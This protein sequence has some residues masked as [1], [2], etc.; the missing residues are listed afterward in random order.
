MTP[1]TPS[2]SE[3]GQ[4]ES[5]LNSEHTDDDLELR[6]VLDGVRVEGNTRTNERVIRRYIPFQP[7]D[8]FDVDDPRVKLTRY[9]LLGTGFFK[10]VTLSLERGANRGHVVLVVSVVERNTLVLND[11]WMGL[12]ASADTNGEQQLLSTFAGVDA[13]E[14]NLFGSGITLG[15]ATAF[16]EDQWALSVR[17]L[18]PAFSSSRWML[19]SEILFNDG[20]GFFGN[21]NVQWDDPQQV[22]EVPR[23]A[24]VTYHRLGTTLGAGVDLS[25]PAQLWLNY[26][27]EGVDAQLP[28]AAAHEYG[29]VLEPIDFH[30]L[31]GRS[32]L[33]AVRATLT[34]DTRDEPWLTNEGWLAS[35]A[36]DISATIF[37]SDYAY[38]KFDLEAARWWR[39][40]N[41][42]I[43]KLEGSLGVISGRAPFFEQYYIGDLSDF[44]PGR[45]LGLAFDDRPAPNF[46]DTSIAEIRYGDYS[47]KINAEYRIPLYR[48]SRSVFGI[49]MFGS[50]G[51]FSLASERDLRR[52]PED[53]RGAARLPV[54]LTA[55]F[56]F[57]MDTSLGGFAF[58]FSNLLGFIPTGGER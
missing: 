30:V 53:I 9:R 8:V 3:S 16:S 28:R 15:S 17:F 25:V 6:Y 35:A 50:F 57:R 37:G 13:A 27:L 1:R 54:D 52:P 48:G 10:D 36:A 38:Q 46:L 26:R 44:R 40:P 34:Y 18:D 12:S 41:S 11:L 22:D 5:E 45:V 33:S 43:I 2:L 24:V 31:P 51:V 32:V 21:S 20:L 29:G 58:S 23:Q 19:A 39:L 7:K 4:P 49:D 47:S 55:G 14:M 56:G 42:H